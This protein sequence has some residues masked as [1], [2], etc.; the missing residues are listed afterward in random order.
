VGWSG[1]LAIAISGMVAVI[2][3]A[4]AAPPKL[5][6]E[7]VSPQSVRLTWPAAERDWV[8][9]GAADPLHWS[10]VLAAPQLEGSRIALVLPLHEP[11]RFWRLRAQHTSGVAGGRNFLRDSQDE[12]GGWG[13]EARILHSAAAMEALLARALAPHP[14]PRALQRQVRQRVAAA[15]ERRPPTLR[16]RF[17]GLLRLPA[18]QRAWAAVAALAVIAVVAALAL[19]AGEGLPVVGTVVGKTETIAAALAAVAV[20]T[21]LAAWFVHKHKR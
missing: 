7:R 18:Y 17:A 2:Q 4:T 11:A 13:G 10:T 12:A 3:P 21:I 8:I 16:E 5:E 14:P 1:R 6:F 15:W 20:I 9:E 19:P